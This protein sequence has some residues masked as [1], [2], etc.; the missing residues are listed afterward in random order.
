MPVAEGRWYACVAHRS[1]TARRSPDQSSCCLL[2]A[3]AL[4]DVSFTSSVQDV[5]ARLRTVA[6]SE[7]RPFLGS[8]ARRR[9]GWLLS[10]LLS[11]PDT[12]GRGDARPARRRAPPSITLETDQS[13]ASADQR[14]AALFLSPGPLALNLWIA[15]EAVAEGLT[16]RSRA[17]TAGSGPQ[18]CGPLLY[19]CAV[20]LS[21]LRAGSL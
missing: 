11:T 3:S 16:C 8:S 15:G 10:A 6:P 21:L 19:F 17:P 9:S 4:H 13:E 14:T 20:W 18:G 1:L 12:Q 5:R 7:R 2:A